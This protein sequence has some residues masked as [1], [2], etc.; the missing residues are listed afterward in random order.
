MAPT[1]EG[2]PSDVPTNE[3]EEGLRERY[4]ENLARAVGID[5][6]HP[7]LDSHEIP[8]EL[9]GLLRSCFSTEPAHRPDMVKFLE[10]LIVT[11]EA[12]DNFAVTPTSNLV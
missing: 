9:R 11:A 7:P 6:E 2:K 4:A 5:G 12:T 3:W 8:G 1:N 10:D